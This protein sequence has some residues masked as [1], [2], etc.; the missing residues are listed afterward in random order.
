MNLD[1]ELAG[2]GAIGNSLDR[3]GKD[4]VDPVVLEAHFSSFDHPLDGDLPVRRHL[5][6]AIQV[7]PSYLEAGTDESKYYPFYSCPQDG[8]LLPFDRLVVVLENLGI[9]PRTPVI[10]Y[11]TEPD[12][13]MAAARLVWGLLVAGVASIRLLDGG[14]GAW[15]AHGGPTVSR[16]E[17]AAEIA[18][19]R[20][21]RTPGAKDDA[22]HRRSEFLA[23]TP[24]VREI[25]RSPEQAAAKLVDVRKPGE[26]DGTLTRYYPFFS[27]A[28][29]I[30][31]ATLQGDW[32]NLIEPDTQQI[33][34]MLEAVRRRWHDLA[35][36]DPA[37]E[38][39]ETSLIFYCGTG[40]R[41]S[42]SFLV[43]T[44]LGFRARNFD[45]GF[46]GWSWDD[47]NEVAFSDS[48]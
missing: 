24:E 47:E 26:Y 45:D 2:P 33:G 3:I 9:T 43:A 6:G 20:A 23:T 39:G 37:V 19:P 17:R 21:A 38:R 10:V 36:I 11:G 32:I 22:W 42:L 41:S 30:P 16:I 31:N 4:D 25:S 15:L 44:L 48:L 27:K 8:N 7:H 35:I 14:I 34:P 1:F 5:P 40:W 28:G 18:G 46:Y 12:G 29:H 13:A